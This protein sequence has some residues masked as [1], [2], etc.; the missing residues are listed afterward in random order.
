[1]SPVETQCFASLAES[2]LTLVVSKK[3]VEKQF[4]TAFLNKETI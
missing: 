4:S 3:A 2:G 1:M